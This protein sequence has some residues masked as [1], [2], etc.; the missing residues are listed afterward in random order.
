MLRIE[1]S[2]RVVLRS[3]VLLCALALF[4]CSM[5]RVGYRQADS[6][7]AWKANQYFDF[8]GSQK[9]EFRA[10]LDRLL[11]WHHREQLPEYAAFLSAARTKAQKPLTRAD[12]VWFVEGI[13]TRYRT[14]VNRGVG[15]AAEMLATLTPENVHALEKQFAKDNREFVREYRLDGTREE[16][17]RESVNR[18]LKQV[19]D[20]TGSLTREQ[21]DRIAAMG[22]AIPLVSPLRH[23]DRVRRQKEFLELLALRGKGD[24]APRLRQ[25]LLNWEEG[26]SP[27]Y[28]RLLD[29]AY[30]KRMAMLMAI[31][32]MLT[33]H[34][35]ATV[36]NRLQDYIDDCK[37]LSD[38]RVNAAS[39]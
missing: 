10:R 20:W 6:I 23:Q 2:Y 12:I 26:R 35:R 15:D 16:Q 36:L 14:I 39:N 17:R 22:R 33:P 7:L 21:E 1:P 32:R 4:G 30:E 11:L 37:A 19:K 28:E 25:W 29:E 13:K 18:T 38:P 5:L 34:Q 9:H 3:V 24:F 27:E 8:D 31:D